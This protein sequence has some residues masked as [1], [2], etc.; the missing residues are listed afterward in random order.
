M[1]L[2]H[3]DDQA[4][5]RDTARSFMAEEGAIVVVA[6]FEVRGGIGDGHCSTILVLAFEIEF[7]ASGWS[8]SPRDNGR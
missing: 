5:L 7:L 6:L 3:T 2:Y 4:M 1:P 8:S